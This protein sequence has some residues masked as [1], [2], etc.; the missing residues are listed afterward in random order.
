MVIGS[1][2]MVVGMAKINALDHA[3][4]NGGKLTISG[5]MGD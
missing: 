1:Q 2:V 3:E 4:F 5:D